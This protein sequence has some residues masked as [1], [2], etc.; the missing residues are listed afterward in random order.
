MIKYVFYIFIVILVY[1]IGGNEFMD[2]FN[3]NGV[4]GKG[5]CADGH[6]KNIYF[7]KSNGK[8][9]INTI[10]KNMSKLSK[11]PNKTIKWRRCLLI[12]ILIIMVSQ[13]VTTNTLPS[14]KN[15]LILLAITYLILKSIFSL[16]QT[17]YHDWATLYMEQNIRK[18]RRHLKNTIIKNTNEICWFYD[19]STW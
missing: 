11:Y 9:D 8:A 2:I 14:V 4:S 18:I 19:Y 6:G 12:S 5:K 10:L 13:C 15:F 7:P 17:H 1:I 3:P 16:Y